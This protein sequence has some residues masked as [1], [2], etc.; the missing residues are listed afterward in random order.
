[1]RIRLWLVLWRVR[2]VRLRGGEGVRGEVGMLRGEEGVGIL[3]VVRKVRGE[4]LG[5]GEGRSTRG[6]EQRRLVVCLRLHA[7]VGGEW[8]VGGG[9]VEPAHV[10]RSFLIRVQRL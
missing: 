1:M 9:Q 4:R 6:G 2:V 8:G 5:A 10:R 7:D 3:V